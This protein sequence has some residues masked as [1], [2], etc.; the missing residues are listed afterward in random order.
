MSKNKRIKNCSKFFFDAPKTPIRAISCVV[1]NNGGKPV[2]L[3]HGSWICPTMSK[4]P[5][6]NEFLFYDEFVVFNKAQIS[7][8]KKNLKKNSKKNI[9]FLSQDS[10]IFNEYKK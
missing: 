6:Y 4:R 8:F 10:N 2:G 9:K 1:K 7:L 5:H 3:P